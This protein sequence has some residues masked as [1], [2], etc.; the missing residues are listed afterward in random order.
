MVRMSPSRPRRSVG[1]LGRNGVEAGGGRLKRPRDDASGHRCWWQQGVGWLQAPCGGGW[2]GLL[3]G[4]SSLF[5][6]NEEQGFSHLGEP[7]S[8]W[9]PPHQAIMGTVG[10]GG[11]DSRWGKGACPKPGMGLG[12]LSLA[13]QYSRC[14]IK[15]KGGGDVL[16]GLVPC[17]C[18]AVGVYGG[19]EPVALGCTNVPRLLSAPPIQAPCSG[20]ASSWWPQLRP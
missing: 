15:G 4:D 12:V 7:A 9:T 2:A 10:V 20:H 19:A 1:L 16:S 11:G 17:L 14:R 5:R 8:C 13:P 3:G 18:V 6:Y